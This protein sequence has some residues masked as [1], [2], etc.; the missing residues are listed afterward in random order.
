MVL[1]SRL[2]L[3]AAV[4]LPL[5]ALTAGCVVESERP[6]PAVAAV[7]II[8]P[9]PPPAV[10]YEVAP[11]LPTERREMLVWDPGHWRWDGHDWDWVPGHYV[12]RPHREAHWEPGH[13]TERPNGKWVWI[14]GQWR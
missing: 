4:V 11:P 7:E 5:L 13:W 10:R 12:E 9:R 3:T 1:S 6:R 14:D 2:L 8:A